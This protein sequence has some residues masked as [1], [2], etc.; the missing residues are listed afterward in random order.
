HLLPSLLSMN[1]APGRF[2]RLGRNPARFCSNPDLGAAQ[3]ADRNVPEVLSDDVVIPRVVVQTARSPASSRAGASSRRTL[4]IA[5]R[6]V[7]RRGLDRLR[8]EEHERNVVDQIVVCHA[9]AS[10]ISRNECP[11]PCFRRSR[12]PSDPLRGGGTRRTVWSPPRR[13]R[14]TLPWRLR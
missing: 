12:D 2:K 6:I 13:T 10:T 8:I 7:G 1:C 9:M 11:G 14:P 3:I 5:A 4:A